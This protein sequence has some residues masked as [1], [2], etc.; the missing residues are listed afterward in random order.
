MELDPRNGGALSR[1][2][3]PAQALSR[4]RRPAQALSRLRRPAQA[5]SR[6]RRPAQAL[7]RL[8]RPAQALSRL[9]RPAQALSRLRRPAQPRTGWVSMTS[10]RLLM[11]L[12]VSGALAFGVVACG[13]DDETAAN[14]GSSAEQAS[15][16]GGG[17]ELSG[18][19]AIDG[20]S[21]VA[22]FAE[23]AAE[24]FQEE[25]SGVQVTVGTSGTGGGFEKFCAGETDISDASRPIE[26]DEA[27]VCEKNAVA[28]SEV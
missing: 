6:L 27:P 22:P 26:D 25:N 21:T 14:G 3:R 7:S 10:N 11:T 8:R 9:R 24:L 20:S 1:L 12:A 5:L 15:S 16:S 19:I 28:Y 23:A 18:Q 17:G 4:L 13:D 2:R